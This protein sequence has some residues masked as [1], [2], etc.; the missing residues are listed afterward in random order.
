M[1]TGTCS[2]PSPW[3]HSIWSSC[4]NG[5][6]GQLATLAGSLLGATLLAAFLLPYLWTSTGSTLGW[7]V[8]RKT[9]GRRAQLLELM[10]EEESVYQARKTATKDGSEDGWE[11]V[12]S[13]A[14]PSVGN[15]EK[16]PRDWDG[17]VGFFHP[18]W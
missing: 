14:V 7:Y 5:V 15:G 9:A 1:D 18:F 2:A 13:L 4:G 11:T 16:A 12:D 17:I 6:V 10:N 8:R 3:H